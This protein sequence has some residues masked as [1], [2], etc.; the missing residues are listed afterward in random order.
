MKRLSAGGAMRRVAPTL[1]DFIEGHD[2]PQ[3]GPH[4]Q[5]MAELRALLQVAQA[6]QGVADRYVKTWTRHANRKEDILVRALARL[7]KVSK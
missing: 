6:A 2:W 1:R 5:R 7:D 4:K 3:Y